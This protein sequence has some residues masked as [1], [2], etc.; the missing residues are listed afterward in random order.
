M[1]KQEEIVSTSGCVKEYEM[2]NMIPFMYKSVQPAWNDANLKDISQ[3][4]SSR[5]IMAHVRAATPGSDVSRANCHPFKYGRLTFQH[6]GRIEEYDK[7]KRYVHVKD[8]NKSILRHIM[9]YCFALSILQKQQ[10]FHVIL[11]C[12]ALPNIQNHKPQTRIT[13]YCDDMKKI[14]SVTIQT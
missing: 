3:S 12:F 14:Y 11:Y 5:T 9:L 10:Q 2:L 4:I 7:I 1:C 13:M 8:M 6:N